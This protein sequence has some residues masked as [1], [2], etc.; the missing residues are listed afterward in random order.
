MKVSGTGETNADETVLY[1]PVF[2]GETF[3]SRNGLISER[4]QQWRSYS[5]GTVTEPGGRGVH[6]CLCVVSESVLRLPIQTILLKMKY[7]EASCVHLGCCQVMAK[8]HL[9]IYSSYFRLEVDN[10]CF[11]PTPYWLW[12][13]WQWVKV[14]KLRFFSFCYSC[15]FANDDT[16]LPVSFDYSLLSDASFELH[17]C[18]YGHQRGALEAS[19]PQRRSYVFITGFI[20]LGLKIHI[21]LLYWEIYRSTILLHL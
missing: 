18:Y 17:S 11:S 19:V 5:G 10:M 14:L 13:K 20:S 7:L 12:W 16:F 6:T 2:C 4:E 15:L 1:F 8:D 21:N 9:I 3:M